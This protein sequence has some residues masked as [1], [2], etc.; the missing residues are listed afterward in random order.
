MSIVAI[1]KPTHTCNFR[2]KYCYVDESAEQGVMSDETLENVIEQ[3]MFVNAL[4]GSRPEFIW[5][6][7]EPLSVGLEFYRKAIEMQQK[8]FRSLV[9]THIRQRNGLTSAYFKDNERTAKNG[10]Q[11]NGSLIDDAVI[12]FCKQYAFH[13]GLSLDGPQEINDETRVFANGSGAY[14]HIRQGVAKARAGGVGGGVIT[15]LTKKNINRILEL[16]EFFKRETINMKVNPLIKSGNAVSHYDD[17]SISAVEYGRAMVQLFD[18]WIDD[19]EAT[20]S[21]DPLDDI[22]GNVLTSKP[23][24]C[25]FSYSCQQN[26]LSIGPLGDVYPCG[27]FDGLAEFRMGNINTDSLNDMLNAPIR[28][29]LLA[30]TPEAFE[31]CMRCDY[32]P[33]CNAGC[34]HNAFMHTGDIMTKDYFCAGYKILF[35]HI[36]DYLSREL[37]PARVDVLVCAPTVA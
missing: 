27:R 18:L 3:V 21:I 29:K 16:Y 22:I 28:T 37:A 19:T 6:G 25:N 5:H 36:T 14:E 13:I 31:S 8:H 17:L 11:S 10:F 15:V 4:Q 26:F 34:I 12:D 33:I 2:C 30:R 23:F 32:K 20:I 9:S 7:G 24:G 1:V 35:N